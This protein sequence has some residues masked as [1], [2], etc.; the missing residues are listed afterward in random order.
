VIE[1]SLNPAQESFGRYEDAAAL[2][3]AQRPMRIIV[4]SPDHLPIDQK[5]YLWVDEILSPLPFAGRRS[6]QA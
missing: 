1:Q 3:L 4:Q 2:H 6:V 5:G